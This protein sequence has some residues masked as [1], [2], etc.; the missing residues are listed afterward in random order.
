VTEEELTVGIFGQ[1]AAPEKRVAAYEGFG[2][3]F[4]MFPGKKRRIS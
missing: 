4:I 3:D 1:E 2:E